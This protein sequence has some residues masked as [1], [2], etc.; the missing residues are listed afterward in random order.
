[1]YIEVSLSL[2]DLS[3][4][5]DIVCTTAMRL[6][7]Q[8]NAS[9]RLIHTLDNLRT[10]LPFQVGNTI[11]TVFHLSRGPRNGALDPWSLNLRFWGAP[12]F[13]PEAPKPLLLK[14]FGAIWGKN[15]GRPKRGSNDHGSNA[16]F[17][18][19]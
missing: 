9:D 8:K 16:P 2:H 17:S 4:V 14:G 5:D 11:C 13:S 1:M 10:R 12:I 19:L 3:V 18:A 7:W 6:K 15:L